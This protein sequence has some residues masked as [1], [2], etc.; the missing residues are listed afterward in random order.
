MNTW[1]MISLALA[2]ALVIVV[3]RGAVQ[4]STA[5]EGE[6]PSA[7]EQTRIKLTSALS[8]LNQ[9]EMQIQS[10]PAA[11]PV[12]KAVALEQITLAKVQV[13]KAMERE[14][15]RPKPAK[16]ADSSKTA[17]LDIQ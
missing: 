1:K 15:M 5:C 7:E 2:G 4:E 17:S 10:A 11:R 16:A 13:R 8:L 3:G 6:A 12:P 9:A 14:M